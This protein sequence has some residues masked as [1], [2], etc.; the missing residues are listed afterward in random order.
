MSAFEPFDYHPE[1][2]FSAI[3]ADQVI[4]T[5]LWR[6]RGEGPW[7]RMHPDDVTG[8]LRS[9]VAEIAD[10]YH[11]TPEARCWRVCS[12]ASEHGRFRKGQRCDARVIAE[13]L[14][15]LAEAFADVWSRSPRT[16]ELPDIT[17]ALQCAGR[18]AHS[19][20]QSTTA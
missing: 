17:A 16:V 18:A 20:Y 2:P 5:W 12:A 14:S 1:Q 13:D 9:V 6:V 8:N 4:E 19:G 7:C 15:A 11:P 10:E 3:S